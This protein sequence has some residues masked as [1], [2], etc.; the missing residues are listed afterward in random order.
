MESIDYAATLDDEGGT[1]PDAD[2]CG[3]Q[4]AAHRGSEAETLPEGR[5]RSV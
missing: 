2:R 5:R 1:A 4:Y 3:P